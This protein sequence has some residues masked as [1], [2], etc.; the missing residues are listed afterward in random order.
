MFS[1]RGP[2]PQVEACYRLSQN[3]LETAGFGSTVHPSTPCGEGR[4][5]ASAFPTQAQAHSQSP[6]TTVWGSFVTT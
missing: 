1:Q 2:K 6:Q 4:I 5:A 3:P